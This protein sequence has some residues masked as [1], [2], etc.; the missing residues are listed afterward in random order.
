MRRV[1]WRVRYILRGAC[2]EIS[3]GFL[4]WRCMRG[5]FLR[6]RAVRAISY[7]SRPS[8][9][10]IPLPWAPPAPSVSV[11]QR[12]SLPAGRSFTPPQPR[13]LVKCS[14]TKIAGSTQLHSSVLF[15]SWSSL[16]SAPWTAALCAFEAQQS[17]NTSLE[18]PYAPTLFLGSRSRKQHLPRSLNAHFA[19]QDFTRRGLQSQDAG[20]WSAA[21]R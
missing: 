4:R 17:D 5:R 3:R 8:A 13:N 18:T 19:C 7:R 12:C 2:Q 11:A 15:V 6:Q 1:F 9:G 20:I 14:P 16:A 10:E 21:R